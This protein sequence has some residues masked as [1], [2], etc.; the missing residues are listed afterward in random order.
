M[1]VEIIT[2]RLSN[3]SLGRKTPESESDIAIRK[4]L[5]CS[6]TKRILRFSDVFSS[7]DFTK[8]L[9]CSGTPTVTKLGEA[10]YSEVFTIGEEDGAVVVKV[11]PLLDSS[12]MGKGKPNVELPDCSEVADAVREIGITKRMSQVP[13]GGFVDFLG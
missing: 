11:V 3:V 10:S 9:P 12:V 5:E 4:L 7:P 2:N 1:E 6:V 13:G 8:L